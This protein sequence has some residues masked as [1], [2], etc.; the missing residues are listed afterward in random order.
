MKYNFNNESLSTKITLLN[1][2]N[3]ELKYSK[4]LKQKAVD[5]IKQ[6]TALIK[7]LKKKI[8]EEQ[9][10]IKYDLI[11]EKLELKKGRKQG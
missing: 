8:K 4:K 1:R 5:Q 6:S 3:S 10:L 7:R 2:L 11:Q 9:N